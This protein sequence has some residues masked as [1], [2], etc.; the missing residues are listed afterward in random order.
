MWLLV[1]V[2]AV[3]LQEHIIIILDDEKCEIIAVEAAGKGIDSGESAATSVLGKKALFM[4][5]KP[6]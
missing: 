5:V 3:M 1:L 6:Y 4:E 2:E